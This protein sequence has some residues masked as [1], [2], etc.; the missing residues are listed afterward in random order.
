MAEKVDLHTHTYF[1]DGILSP[2]ALVVLAAERGISCLSITDHDS[3]DGLEEATEAGREYG[4]EI[5]PGV[6]LSATLGV[7]DIHILGYL[8]DPSNRALRTTLDLFK[9]E[10]FHRA[11]RIVRKLNQLNIPLR[12]D[13]VLERAGHGAIGRPHIAEALVEEGL[14]SDYVQAFEHY[15]GDSGPAYEPKYRIS[16]E[17]AMAII[18]DAGGISILAHPGWYVNEEELMQLIRAGLDGIETVHPAH[19]DGRRRFYRD[20]ASAY[21]LLESGGSDYH[22]GRRNDDENFGTCVVGREI[23]AAMR[24]RLF[25]Q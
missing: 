9:K 3:I 14:T 11:V 19:D 18:A 22:G 1:S 12:F 5:I 16:P 8:F 13:A 2:R 6:E 21:F 4:V 10:R 17:D 24:R 25:I 7:K 20:I 15:I 23:P